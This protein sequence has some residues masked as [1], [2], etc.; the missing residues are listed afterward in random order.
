MAILSIIIASDPLESWA[1]SAG[2]L[3]VFLSLDLIRMSWLIAV[4]ARPE[5][6]RTTGLNPTDEPRTSLALTAPQR[7]EAEA[8][9]E[10][11]PSGGSSWLVVVMILLVWGCSIS[12]VTWLLLPGA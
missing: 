8:G 11:G 9:A 12:S 4:A 6:S 7:L 5:L 1:V 10:L 2:P 3:R